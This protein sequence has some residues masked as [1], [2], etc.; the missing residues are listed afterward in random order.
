MGNGLVFGFITGRAAAS[1]AGVFHARCPADDAAQMHI[2]HAQFLGQNSFWHARHAKYIR[3][4]AHQTPHFCFARKT[5][6]LQ[7]G[8]HRFFVQM[9]IGDF[10]GGDRNHFFQA[11]VVRLVKRRVQKFREV[12]QKFREVRQKFREVWQKFR[13]VW[14]KFR[15]VWQKFREV[16]Q[17]FRE[18]WQKFREV[19]QKFREVWQKFREVWQKFREVPQKFRE[20][21][22]H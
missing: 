1:G 10:I 13:E 16:W 5:R 6:A 14:Q 12:R 17:K 8:I 11:A 20:A 15:E 21:Q 4:I 7:T 22:K 19:W 9:R 3:A 18:V 2:A